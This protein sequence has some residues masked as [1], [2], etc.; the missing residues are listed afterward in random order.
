MTINTDL[1]VAAPMLQDYFVDKDTGKPL[2]NGLVSLYRDTARSFY[3]NWYYQTGTPGAYT[4][5]ALDNP[6]NLSSVG[7]IQDPNGNDV[8]P[9]FYPY[10]ENAENIKDAYYVTVY[11][12]DENGESAVLQFTR[13]NFPFLPSNISPL[14]TSPTWRNYILNNIYWRNIGSLDAMA[15]LDQVIAPSQHDGYTNGDIRFIKNVAGGNDDILFAPMTQQL[16]NDIT[17]ETMLS[18]ACTGVMVGETTKCIQY[19]ISLHV[20]TL[21]SV[22][23][24]IIFHGQNVAGNTNNYVDLYFYQYLGDG[25]LAQ[26]DPIL[27]QRVVLNNDFTRTLVPF[28]TPS[29]DGLTLGGGGNDALFLRVQYPL[30][31]LCSINHTKPQIYFS[32]DVPDNDF[33]TY[34]Q[35]E[36]II[37]SPRTGDVKVSLNGSV[38]NPTFQLLGYVPMNDGTIGNSS[39]NATCRAKSDTFPLFKLIWDTF[40]YFTVGTAN[41]IAQLYDSAGVA[42]AYGA[43]AITDY[44]ANK[45]ISLTKQLGRT[46]LGTV[47]TSSSLPIAPVQSSF[48]AS[49]GGGNLLV[50]IAVPNTGLYLGMPIVFT[51]TGGALPGNLN[52][53]LMYATAIQSSTQFYVATT[54]ANALAGT[55]VAYSTAGSGNNLVNMSVL[56]APTGEYQHSQLASEVGAHTHTSTFPGTSNAT[57]VGGGNI[58]ISNF[59]GSPQSI[60]TINANSNGAPFNVVQPSSYMNM[61]IKL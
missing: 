10:E 46:L 14:A 41:G 45:A 53:G 56:G 20:K 52:V 48:T 39:S 2:A 9:F 18:F 11:S 47:T 26:P 24:T 59:S 19:P 8:I 3:K 25:A 51:N 38:F 12:V 60:V 21:N 35:V 36:T 17:P 43:D 61:Y 7:T 49:N 37:N 22:S 58:V 5:V 34:D 50:T 42:S 57:G 40:H 44:N 16:D 28:I 23:G 15:V 31:A 6:M 4:W 54:Y 29:T 33:D 55:L 13:E 30:S 27:I 1:L 32:N